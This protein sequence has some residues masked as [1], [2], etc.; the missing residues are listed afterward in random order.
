MHWVIDNKAPEKTKKLAKSMGCISDDPLEIANFLQR[1]PDVY[2]FVKPFLSTPTTNEIFY[3]RSEPTRPVIEKENPEAIITRSPVELMNDENSIDVPVMMGYTSAEGIVILPALIG[4]L[5]EFDNDLTKLIPKSINLQ[6]KDLNTID[7]AKSIRDFY[8]KGEK[9]N[10]KT[11]NNFNDLLGDFFFNINYYEAAEIHSRKQHKSPLF[12]YRFDYDGAL[13]L[14]KNKIFQMGH[15]KGV[16]HADELF[17]IFQAAMAPEP[18]EENAKK[19]V[20][21]TCK[22]WTNFAKYGNPTSEGGG[23]IDC[24]WEPVKKIGVKDKFTLNAFIIDVPLKMLE[25][26]DGER[27]DFWKNVKKTYKSDA[28]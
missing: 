15:L 8:F 9:V 5:E 24:T 1:F 27:I 6:L 14:Y 12:F 20:E 7:L 17:Y 23:L 25:N 28:E 18:W 22:L 3:G 19:M 21:T 10:E 26:P 2:E 4:N 13:N 11:L 16:S